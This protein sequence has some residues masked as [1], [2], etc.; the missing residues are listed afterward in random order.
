MPINSC[1]YISKNIESLNM[2]IM[3]LFF[4]AA[5]R[6]L[7]FYSIISLVES[8]LHVASFFPS[9]FPSPR[10]P[11]DMLIGSQTYVETQA[12]ACSP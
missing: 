2:S 8:F 4:N 3:L 1:Y 6:Y 12:S 11:L 10:L 5:D 9:Y 7:F